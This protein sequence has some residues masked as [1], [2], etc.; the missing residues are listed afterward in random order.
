MAEVQLFYRSDVALELLGIMYLLIGS[1]TCA[2][3]DI[4]LL[5]GFCQPS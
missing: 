5:L 2:N 3:G 4:S 1:C